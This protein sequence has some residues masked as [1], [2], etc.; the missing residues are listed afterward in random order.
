VIASKFGGLAESVFE[1]VTA[2]LVLKG[3]KAVLTEQLARYL[4]DQAFFHKMPLAGS[5]VYA[6]EFTFEVM[7]QPYSA[8]VSKR[9]VYKSKR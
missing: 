1:G 6:R 4:G 9:A 7:Y 2:F 5:L 3:N 8:G